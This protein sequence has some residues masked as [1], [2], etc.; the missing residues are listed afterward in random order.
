MPVLRKFPR[1]TKKTKTAATTKRIAAIAKRTFM[2]NMETKKHQVELIEQPLT[3]IASLASNSLCNIAQGTGYAQRVGHE[4][5]VSGFSIQGQ[6]RQN[7]IGSNNQ[8][9]VR[10]LVLRFKKSDANPAA[11]LLENDANNQPVSPDDLRSLYR[12]VN[13]DSYEVLADKHITL[14]GYQGNIAACKIFKMWIPFRKTLRYDSTAAVAPNFNKVHVIA[15]A[16]DSG[17]DNVA[18]NVEFSYVSN[19]YYKDN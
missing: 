19:M 6:V 18:P 3:S 7:G 1:Y 4:I 8:D 15:F 13:M 17:N 9:I 10:I 2:K 5:S 14:G 11:D 12:R 16:R